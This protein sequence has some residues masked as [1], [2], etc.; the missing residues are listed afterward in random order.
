MVEPTGKRLPL[1]GPAVWLVVTPGQ[2]S[3]A[4]G[5]KVATAPQRP[6]EV[7]SVMLAGQVTEGPAASVTETVKEQ[8]AELPLP[9]TTTKETVVVPT[10]N[11]LPLAG[12][13]VCVGETAPQLSVADAAKVTAA[14]QRPGPLPTV[15][16]LGHVNTGLVRSGVWETTVVPVAVQPALLVTTQL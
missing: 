10:G 8:L 16:L 1:A 11:T 5:A 14:P 3:A 12:P 2:L 15:I 13:A 4:V 9:S 6:G 7:F